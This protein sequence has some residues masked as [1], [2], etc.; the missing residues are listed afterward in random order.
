MTRLIRI[1]GSL[2]L[3][4]IV[5]SLVARASSPCDEFQYSRA[6]DATARIDGCVTILLQSPTASAYV[7]VYGS[8]KGKI[9][10][11]EAHLEQ[12]A[13]LIGKLGRVD[14][15]RVTFAN[16]G[17]RDKLTIVFWIV[18]SGAE[19]PKPVPWFQSEEVKLS[20]RFTKKRLYLFL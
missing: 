8:R 16:G 13:T 7:I 5:C 11:V 3:L 18:P 10:E 9:G 19:L 14:K 2:G 4:V 1:I 15:S 12:L 17:Y 6:A 20:G